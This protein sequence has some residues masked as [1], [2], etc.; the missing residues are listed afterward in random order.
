MDWCSPR[1]FV[2]LLVVVLFHTLPYSRPSSVSAFAVTSLPF[3]R[4]AAI[5]PRHFMVRWQSNANRHDK[6]ANGSDDTARNEEEDDTLHDNSA[7]VDKQQDEDESD[8][9]LVPE[10]RARKQER[11]RLARAEALKRRQASAAMDLP[12]QPLVRTLGGGTALIFA[13]ARR[14][15]HEDAAAGGTLS[16][17]A[18][19]QPARSA[20]ASSSS[21]PLMNN[22]GYAGSI[23]RNVRK[24]NKPALWR[25][26]LRT[27]DRMAVVDESMSSTGAD[28]SFRVERT[29]VHHEGALLACA[30]LGLWQ[31]ALDIYREVERVECA[32]L[33]KQQSSSTSSTS[34]TGSRTA[35]DPSSASRSA[36]QKLPVHVTDAM[37]GSVVRAC[38]RASRH[39]TP[40][41]V[42][43][44][45]DTGVQISVR[46]VPLDAAQEVVLAME[47]AHGLPLVA[48]HLNPL[49]AAYTNLGLYAEAAD[50]LESHL[51][52]RV[53]GPEAENGPNV[54]NVK[55]IGAK[56][57]SSYA[58]LVQ[59]A[60]TQ[61]DW[62]E[63]VDALRDM[64]EAGLYPNV[65]HLNV[66]TEV[67]ERKSKHRDTRSWKKKR[68]Q[69]W[70]SSIRQ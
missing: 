54:L 49:A 57:K 7:T 36:T 1:R 17:A 59:A 24:R 42:S 65:R 46:R 40:A 2:V 23:W 12:S 19:T 64:T 4:N 58:L 48:R 33:H 60:V 47:A 31:R 53:T 61:G 21:S 68:D 18:T 9:T 41:G 28:S 8:S 44:D 55:D 13:M 34:G 15:W 51:T 25:Y 70:V 35:T 37:I 22:Q 32:A 14:M 67:S 66:W 50:L 62:S 30:K 45:N 39:R 16:N 27:Y 6:P 56:D 43:L 26:A 38:V 29:N 10:R 69:A 5:L 3:S 52:E 11:H 20:A 63:A